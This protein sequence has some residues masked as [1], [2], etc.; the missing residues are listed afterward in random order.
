MLVGRSCIFRRFSHR[1]FPIITS[2]FL[3]VFRLGSFGDS[4]I[5][6]ARVAPSSS[7]PDVAAWLAPDFS[8]LSF[9]AELVP[10]VFAPPQAP[11]F[12]FRRDGTTGLTSPSDVLDVSLS[13]LFLLILCMPTIV[14]PIF[15]P[16]SGSL[17]GCI[18]SDHFFP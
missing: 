13:R 2:P 18:P 1:F 4:W 6:V 14:L 15:H 8:Y 10:V 5:Y 12:S 17:Y 11:L 16:W 9:G 7:V 3:L